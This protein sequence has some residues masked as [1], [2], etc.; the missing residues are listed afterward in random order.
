MNQSR[1]ATTSDLRN[2]D[3]IR[4]RIEMGAVGTE[5]LPSFSE[6]VKLSNSAPQETQSFY[7]TEQGL[8]G[9]EGE[10]SANND[11]IRFSKALQKP[12]RLEKLRQAKPIE[13]TGKE[14][15]PS[16]DLRQYKRNALEYGKSLRGSYVNKDTGKAIELGAGGV[17]EILQHDYKDIE[18]LQSIAAVPQIIENAIYIDTLPNEDKAKNFAIDGYE[19][20]LAGLKIGGVDYTV[21]AV[22]GV[23]KDGNR[24]Y[25]H[26]LTK[27]EKGELLSLPS[28]ITNPVGESSSPLSS[29]NDKR[30]LQI[31]QQQTKSFD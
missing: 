19:Y 1:G 30:L 28:R 29:I 21:R 20:Y 13:I 25:D 6:D 10:F 16:D 4:S 5:N 12:E 14:I 26:K 3:P 27:I 17:K 8:S 9:K 24:Y 18:H 31:L 7:E 23:T 15:Q 22:V 11:D 2:I